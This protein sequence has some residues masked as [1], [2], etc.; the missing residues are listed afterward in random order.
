MILLL[1]LGLVVVVAAVL[2]VA[3][4]LVWPGG[5]HFLQR[6]GPP[7]VGLAVVAALFSVLGGTDGESNLAVVLGLLVVALAGLG[8]VLTRRSSPVA[9]RMWSAPA[10]VPTRIAGPQSRGASKAGSVA[11]ALGRVEARELATS[12]WF[13]VGAGFCVLIYVLFGFAWEDTNGET[14]NEYAQV[15]SWFALPLVGMMV[16]SSHRAVTRASRDGADELF[17]TCPAAPATRTVGFLVAGSVPVIALTGFF[18]VLGATNAVR[19][20]F[21]HGPFGVDSLADITAAVV[22]GAGGVTLGVGLGRWVRFALAPVVAVVAIGV[23]TISINGV[24][25]S[26]WNPL[27]AL[28]TAPTLEG[29]SP[30]FAD[31]RVFGHLLWLVGLTV[32]VGIVALARHRRD[33]TVALMATAAAVVVVV[34]GIAATRPMPPASAARIADLVA[35]PEAHQ[36][37]ASLDGPAAVCVFPFHREILDQLVDRVG[38]IAALLPAEL[39]PLTLRQVFEGDLADLPPEVRRRLTAS[40]LVRPPREVRLGYG[41]DLADAERGPGFDL[42]FAAVGLPLEAD[43]HLLPTVVAGEARGVVALWLAT[44]GLASGNAAERATSP[45]PGSFDAFTRGSIE[46]VDDPCNAPAVVW[47]AQDLDAARAVIALNEAN[48]TRT[49]QDDWDRW[50]DPRTARARTPSSSIASLRTWPP[51]VETP[52]SA[53]WATPS[54]A[55]RRSSPPSPS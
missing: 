34:S 31:R 33:R 40:D 3:R 36:E 25:G 54:T 10:A 46:A 6:L 53:R 23:A 44:R 17:D 21:L 22:L 18:V 29:P 9:D 41:E 8:I 2:L 14:W 26:D 11:Q 16:L 19:S 7:L 52:R 50:V 47:S 20:P 43:D 45:D 27:V 12:P 38:P 4:E 55:S 51:S 49:V 32:A 28:S 37:C 35:R 30:V 24:G 13:G 15:A 48:V 1:A 39:D 5:E 42:A